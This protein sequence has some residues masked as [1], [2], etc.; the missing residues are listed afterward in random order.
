[1]GKSKGKLTSWTPRL[2][3][4][5]GG[6]SVVLDSLDDFSFIGDV[7]IGEGKD[8]LAAVSREAS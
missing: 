4:I 3:N 1:M 7:A 2:V 5:H 8:A 6:A